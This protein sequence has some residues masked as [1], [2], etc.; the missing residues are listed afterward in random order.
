MVQRT[1][2]L[3]L[4]TAGGLAG[5]L[6][7]LAG[8]AVAAIRLSRRAAPRRARAARRCAGRCGRHRRDREGAGAVVLSLGL[9]LSVLAAVGQID[10]NLRNAISGSCPR[11]RRPI[12]S[13]ISRRTRCRALPTRLAGDPAVREVDSA[14]MLRGSS[15]A[16]TATARARGGGRSLGAQGDRGV[17]Y[18]GALPEDT[19]SPRG[20]AGGARLL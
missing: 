17:T 15:P 14:P 9:G 20:A 4:W 13:S 12:S 16:S 5:S 8:A 2:A 7:L 3:T 11:S 18:S 10:G 6:I 1:L 19:R